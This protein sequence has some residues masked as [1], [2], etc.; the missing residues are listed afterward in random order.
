MHPQPERST[1]AFDFHFRP[2][3]VIGA[4]NALIRDQ[5]VFRN[6]T[7]W[8]CC[9]PKMLAENQRKKVPFPTQFVGQTND[10]LL[11]VIERSFSS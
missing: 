4:Q 2:P 11:K 7:E 3:Y 5:Q 9:F 6:R 10:S 8:N 1:C